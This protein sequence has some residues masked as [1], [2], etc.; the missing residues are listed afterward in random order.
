MDGGGKQKN[1]R[2]RDTGQRETQAENKREGKRDKKKRDQ[3][4]VFEQR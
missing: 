3:V 1:Q 2:E 4:K